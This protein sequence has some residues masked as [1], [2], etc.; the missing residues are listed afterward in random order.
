M[1]TDFD[2]IEYF[3]EWCQ[4]ATLAQLKSELKAAL[5]M[6]HETDSDYLKSK[7]RQEI[8]ILRKNIREIEE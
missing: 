4:L 2:S 1:N 6:L 5:W 7:A 3:K 8:S